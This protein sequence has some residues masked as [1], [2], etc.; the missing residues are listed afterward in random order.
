MAEADRRDET[1]RTRDE[2]ARARDR[3]A[4]ERDG[5]RRGFASLDRL[6]AAEDRK[7]AAADRERARADRQ[8]LLHELELAAT[9]ALTGA[10]ARAAGLADLDLEITRARRTAA[11]LVVAYVDVIGLK[12]RNDT[13]GHDSGDRLL[14]RVVDTLTE[15]LRAYDLVIRLGGDEFLCAMSGASLP[16]AHR[17]FRR[18]AAT[19][20]GGEDAAEIT[21]GFAELQPDEAA[22]ELVARADRDMIDHR[23]TVPGTRANGNGNG[24]GPV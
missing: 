20:A 15:H 3:A 22:A 6:A 16:D 8:A 10:R 12:V 4:E 23:R 5:A 24:T 18:V 19:L 2:A 11:A 1:A 9:D 14:K 7:R 13:Y 17:R 21:A